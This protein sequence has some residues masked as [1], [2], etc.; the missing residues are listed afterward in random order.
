MLRYLEKRNPY[1]DI[2]SIALDNF[3]F[4]MEYANLRVKCPSITVERSEYIYKFLTNDHSD[5]CYRSFIHNL[6]GEEYF[7]V[8]DAQYL[9]HRRC[10]ERLHKIFRTKG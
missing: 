2:K 1:D 4:E 5:N 9:L 3:D 7:F 8:L 6:N 10:L